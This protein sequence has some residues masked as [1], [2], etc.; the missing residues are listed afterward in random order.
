MKVWLAIDNRKE[1]QSVEKSTKTDSFIG[2]IK[3]R[4]FLYLSQLLPYHLI[5]LIILNNQ[6]DILLHLNVY[7]LH[8]FA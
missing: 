8:N 1:K 3:T 7:F 2:F 6:L 5:I 4:S